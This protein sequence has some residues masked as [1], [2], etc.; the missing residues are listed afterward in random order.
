M[1]LYLREVSEFLDTSYKGPMDW[2]RTVKEVYDLGTI[3]RRIPIPPFGCGKEKEAEIPLHLEYWM[4]ES[5]RVR[6]ELVRLLTSSS[7]L[8]MDANIFIPCFGYL[9]GGTPVQK[10]TS[11]ESGKI[12]RSRKYGSLK[13]DPLLDEELHELDDLEFV[14]DGELF[15][16]KDLTLDGVAQIELDVIEKLRQ[17]PDYIKDVFLLA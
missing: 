12:I 17:L 10:S 9:S 6:R 14:R 16:G 7:A 11:K 1:K 15:L 5:E 8:F 3:V 13:S 4:G 2:E